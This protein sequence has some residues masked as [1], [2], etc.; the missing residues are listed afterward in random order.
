M[1]APSGKMDVTA[2]PLYLLFRALMR[3]QLEAATLSAQYSVLKCLWYKN[4]R[5]ALLQVGRGFPVV[6][7]HSMVRNMKRVNVRWEHVAY[8]EQNDDYHMTCW[9]ADQPPRFWKWQCH[10]ELLECMAGHCDD[11]GKPRRHLKACALLKVRSTFAVLPSLDA[12]CRLSA[13]TCEAYRAEASRVVLTHFNGS[14]FPTC[15]RDAVAA[16]RG[17]GHVQQ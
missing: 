6:A 1:H 9:P 12:A 14:R 2:S 11:L 10:A 7:I 16:M 4:L 13:Y 17:A 3:A 15:V 8:W 5:V